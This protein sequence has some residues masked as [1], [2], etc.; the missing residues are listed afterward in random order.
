MLQELYKKVRAILNKLTPE[1]FRTLVKQIQAL[2]VDSADQLKGVV[3]LIFEK[4]SQPSVAAATLKHKCH[5]DRNSV[6]LKICI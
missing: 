3:N 4:V 1:K 2:P 5:I 6:Y